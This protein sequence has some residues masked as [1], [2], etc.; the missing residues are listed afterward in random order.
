LALTHYLCE[1]SIYFSVCNWKLIQ[2]DYLALDSILDS[3]ADDEEAFFIVKKK[4]KPYLR[5]KSRHTGQISFKL[6]TCVEANVLAN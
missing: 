4:K 5:I 2:L 6:L 1:F 3:L